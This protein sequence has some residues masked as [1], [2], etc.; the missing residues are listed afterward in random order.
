MTKTYYKV[1]E[2]QAD[3]QHIAF[4]LGV[5]RS[6][7]PL[8]KM[9]YVTNGDVAVVTPPALTQWPRCTG[10]GNFGT[11]WGPTDPMKAKYT[12]DL[13]D[14]PINGAPNEAFAAF[15]V[16]IDALDDLL[17]DF[18]TANQ[19]EI[20]GRTN[21]SREEVSTFQIRSIR[22]K[23][24]KLS[25]AFIGH[26]LNL[27]TAKWVSDGCGGKYAR[28]ITIC[29]FYGT[30]IEVNPNVCPGDIVA[31]TMYASQVYTGVGD[32][33]FGIHWSFEDVSIVAQR[34]ALEETRTLS[35][36]KVRTASNLRHRVADSMPRHAQTVY[37][38]LTEHTTPASDN[39]SDEPIELAASAHQ[40]VARR[41]SPRFCSASTWQ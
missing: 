26:T 35:A 24:D 20:L 33:Q 38:V 21:L 39:S 19:L 41:T 11:M 18:V 10:D 29:D 15:K 12:L 13:N 1:N 34:A 28:K 27:S 6:G 3:K 2:F 23:Y 32:D 25:G 14:V 36:F 8:V 9:S 22:P 17:L 31:A 37:D 16:K 5:Q 30:V 4:S 40:A 7:K